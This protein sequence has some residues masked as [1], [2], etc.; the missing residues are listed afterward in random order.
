MIPGAL[1]AIVA[2]LRL[3]PCATRAASSV[4]NANSRQA[5]LD[6]AGWY[7]ENSDRHPHGVGEKRSNPWGLFDVHGNA[8]EWTLS[9]WI[10]DYSGRES[11]VAIN[12]FTVDPSDYLGPAAVD[13]V[14]RGGSSHLEARCARAAWRGQWDSLSVSAG[15]RVLLP[16]PGERAR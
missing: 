16:A 7:D 13:R 2:M 15:F 4:V 3:V 1:C 12:P 5:G 14:I 8:Y 6:S 9:R 10:K 11:G